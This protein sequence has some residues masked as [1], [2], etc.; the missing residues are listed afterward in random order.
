MERDTQRADA[1]ATKAASRPPAHGA[2]WVTWTISGAAVIVTL[3][4]GALL[5]GEKEN[6]PAAVEPEEADSDTAETPSLPQLTTRG[7]LD[8]SASHLDAQQRARIWNEA[9]MLSGVSLVIENGKPIAEIE[10][11][12]G[13][14]TGPTTPG[15]SLG[16][17][18]YVVSYNGSEVT[19]TAE[20][21]PKR[22]VAISPPNCTLDAAYR[23]L[24]Q[25]G[26]PRSSRVGVML[27]QSEK[28]RRPVWLMTTSEGSAYSIN[29]E[30]CVLLRR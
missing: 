22:R 10:F 26:V 21:E 4:A 16:D 1:T 5:L 24:I 2:Q 18:R 29:A 20:E 23:V 27:L 19:A 14:S 9:S 12:F 8:L 15:T 30:S 3:A 6:V 7:P 17:E 25:A 11:A 13:V 28:H